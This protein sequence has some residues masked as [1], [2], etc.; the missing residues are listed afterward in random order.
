M[1]KM[2]E[3]SNGRDCN[4]KVKIAQ[5]NNSIFRGLGLRKSLCVTVMAMKR[6]ANNQRPFSISSPRGDRTSVRPFLRPFWADV[7]F[8]WPGKL[9]QR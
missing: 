7:Y 4:E 5:S 9:K 6:F 2:K 3:K 1:K 8:S